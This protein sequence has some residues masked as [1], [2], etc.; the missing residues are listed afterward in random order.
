ML[1]ALREAK[2]HSSWLNPNQAYE[3]AIQEFILHILKPTRSRAFLK[4]F[5]PF[6]QTVAYY[7]M[8][9]SLSQVLMKITAP[10][11]PD[12]YQGTE[13]WDL[14]L[15]DPDNRRPIPYENYRQA[16]EYLNQ[17][18][19]REGTL[20][21]LKQLLEHPQNGYLKLWTTTKALQ[22]RKA[23]ASLYLEGK[24]QPLETEGPQSPHVCAFGR[25]EGEQTA[26]TIIPRFI[27]SLCPESGQWPLGKE[28]WENTNLLLP[29][30]LG[31]A[32][33]TNILTGES[34]VSTEHQGRAMVQVHEI[35]KHFP[36]ALLER[37]A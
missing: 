2:V 16:L 9:N 11:I 31:G 23:H 3:S 7:G 8:V 37:T 28:V 22:Y 5:L 29:D 17:T 12:F 36:V 32:Q 24:F 1:K 4:D 30:T 21:L 19:Q 26:I 18:Q 13:L 34:M 25:I 20:E 14:H 6:Q 15:V 27:S 10:G 35:L 33:L